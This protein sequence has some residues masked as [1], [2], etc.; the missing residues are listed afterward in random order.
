MAEYKGDN[1]YIVSCEPKAIDEELFADKFP[2]TLDK[3]PDP[4]PEFRPPSAQSTL[5]SATKPKPKQKTAK[6][7]ADEQY[8][9]RHNKQQAELKA[10]QIG[11]REFLDFLVKRVELA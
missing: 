5:S 7:I 4:E 2:Y 8:M 9:I 1:T 3:R 10:Q 11:Y 6:D